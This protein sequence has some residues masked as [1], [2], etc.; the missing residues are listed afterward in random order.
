VLVSAVDQVSS[1]KFRDPALASLHTNYKR[2]SSWYEYGK[3]VE[4]G[5]PRSRDDRDETPLHVAA[6][7]GHVKM[8]ALLLSRGADIAATALGHTA[9]HRA[10][11]G[12]H[13]DV[14]MLLL[15]GGA[16][17]HATDYGGTTALH[18][19]AKRGDKDV[20]ALLLDKGADVIATDA[21]VLRYA[22]EWGTGTWSSCYWTEGRTSP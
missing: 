20:V 9:L 10:A 22:A 18:E 12:G 3:D 8:V 15:D 13:K 17:V 14:V 7:Q 1:E 5:T 21:L 6:S 2:F 16:D 4:L 19:G 11:E